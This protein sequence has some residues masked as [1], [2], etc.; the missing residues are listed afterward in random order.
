MKRDDRTSE[1]FGSLLQPLPSKRAFEE[2]SGQ[3]KELILSR[4]L[5]PGD[6][7]P[8]ERE[9]AVHFRSGR[10][11]VREALRIL[12]QSGLISV[13]KGN[14]GG[15]FIKDVDAAAASGSLLD[16]IKRTDMSLHDLFV[17]RVPIEALVVDLA[18]EHI[19]SEEIKALRTSIRETQLH[20][21]EQKS[22]GAVFVAQVA[23]GNVDFHIEL[24]KATGNVLLWI[25]MESLMRLTH[26]FF[27]KV[28]PSID[29][30][31]NHVEQHDQILEAIVKKDEA[32]AHR[33][34]TLHN[35]ALKEHFSQL[36]AADG[37]HGKLPTS[38]GMI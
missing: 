6:K 15:I 11:A 31:K 37:E 38:G 28:V 8:T 27:A 32:E 2:I 36:L 13:K 19:S 17:V 5:R 30:L 20:L 10:T 23:K 29:F 25:L 21:N 24:A 35:E 26:L 18:L 16:T 4:T 22:S 34:L 14:E 12:E 33:L 3:I 9:L 7:L 1:R